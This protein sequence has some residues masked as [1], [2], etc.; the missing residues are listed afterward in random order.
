MSYQEKSHATEEAYDL[1]LMCMCS[2]NWALHHPDQ[3]LT[4]AW[5]PITVYEAKVANSQN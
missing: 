3:A 2:H 1:G 5:S 4:G